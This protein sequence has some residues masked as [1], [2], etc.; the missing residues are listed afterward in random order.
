MTLPVLYPGYLIESFEGYLIKGSNYG[1]V[2]FGDFSVTP[3][4]PVSLVSE[5]DCDLGVASLL[6]TKSTDDYSDIKLSMDGALSGSY[7]TICN[8]I[9]FNYKPVLDIDSAHDPLI[10]YISTSEGQEKYITSSF[11]EG[12]YIDFTHDMTFV[13]GETACSVKVYN[14]QESCFVDTVVAYS[15][16]TNSITLRTLNQKI[17]MKS[18]YLYGDIANRAEIL[19]P[20]KKTFEPSILKLDVW[21][22]TASFLT[23]SFL[24]EEYMGTAFLNSGWLLYYV[25]DGF[26]MPCFLTDLEYSFDSK[27]PTIYSGNITLEEYTGGGVLNT[28][29][30]CFGEGGIPTSSNIDVFTAGTVDG[31]V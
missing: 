1:T 9:A 26:R 27:K 12:G 18:N 7:A 8:N 10:M 25:G 29:R 15:S 17:D 30:S 13:A 6:L 16:I 19:T 4:S 11:D 21:W 23:E 5:D 14:F 3:A 22:P 2:S 20:K 24:L 31:M 28:Y